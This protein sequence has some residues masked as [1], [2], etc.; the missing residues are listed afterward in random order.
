M[1][2]YFINWALGRDVMNNN[3][4]LLKEIEDYELFLFK[5]NRLIKRSRFSKEKMYLLL[6]K[7]FPEAAAKLY[8]NSIVELLA[9][10]FRPLDPICKF[11]DTTYAVAVSSTVS[12]PVELFESRLRKQKEKLH[13]ND[14]NFLLSFAISP[15]ES[16]N[17]LNLLKI[18]HSRMEERKKRV[19]ESLNVEV[20]ETA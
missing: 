5:V 1:L 7:F 14:L 20:P 19:E 13:L 3:Y 9:N 11:S 10:S 15:Y 18:A 2:N 12:I 4:L 16:T 17:F 6:L 8:S